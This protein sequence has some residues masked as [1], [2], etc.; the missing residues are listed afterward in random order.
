[1]TRVTPIKVA[2]LTILVLAAALVSLLFV[3]VVGGEPAGKKLGSLPLPGFSLGLT[4]EASAALQAGGTAFPGPDPAGFAA[5]WS[6]DASTMDLVAVRDATLRVNG[7]ARRVGFGNLIDLGDNFF[8]A[9][10]DIKN[11]TGAN[12]VRLFVSRPASGDTGDTTTWVVAYF[13]DGSVAAK[14]EST[15]GQGWT[16]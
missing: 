7:T 3:F 15:D 8:I 5:I 2:A 16:A 12:R 11:I 1:M 13:L 9:D 4:A 6:G 10:V 14:P